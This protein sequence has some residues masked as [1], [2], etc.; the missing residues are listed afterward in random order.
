MLRRSCAAIFD[1]M[2]YKHRHPRFRALS[3]LAFAHGSETGF[4][5]AQSRYHSL[6]AVL[7]LIGM[8]V[9]PTTSPGTSEARE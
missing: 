8:A 6:V 4:H 1:L 2:F 9:P 7:R 5:G 3:Q